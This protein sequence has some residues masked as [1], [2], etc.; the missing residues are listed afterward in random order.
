MRCPKADKKAE[1]LET[2]AK[3]AGADL[4]E[5]IKKAEKESGEALQK[6]EKESADKVKEAKE[7]RGRALAARCAAERLGALSAGRAHARALLAPLS[8]PA[9]P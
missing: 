3:K 9:A 4:D 5:K 7:V 2:A 1:E 8:D 6:A